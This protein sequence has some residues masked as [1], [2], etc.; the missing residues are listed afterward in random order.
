[1]DD[2]DLFGWDT[3]FAVNFTDTNAAIVAGHATPQ[4]FEYSDAETDV[5]IAGQW[6]DWQL[7]CGG[8]GQNAH[9]LC[10]ITQGTA[11]SGA[12]QTDLSGSWLKIEVRLAAVPDP[13]LAFEDPTGKGGV[14]HKLVVK[15]T[16]T[17]TD[18]AVSISASSFPHATGLLVRALPSIF[19]AYFIDNIALFNHVFSVVM[20]SETAY[21]DDY[22]WMKPTSMSYAV[23]DASDGSLDKS[24][25]S[26]LTMTGNKP[27]GIKPHAVDPRILDG[28]PEGAN[29]ALGLSGVNVLRHIFLPGAVAVIQGSKTEDYLIGDDGLWLENKADL[30]WGQFELDDGKIVQ[31]K[32]AAGKFRVG[33]EGDSV[34]L[35]ITGASFPWPSWHGPG[36]I[37]VSMNLVQ[38]FQF[39]LQPRGDGTYVFIPKTGSTDVE[40]V[41][42]DVTTSPGVDIFSVCMS[43]GT[44]VVLAIGGALFGKLLSCEGKIA[45]K[46]TKAAITIG[47]DVVE[48]TEALI[49]REGMQELEV[50]GAETASQA[51]KN[52]A[53]KSWTQ[54]FTSCIAAQ[55]WKILG[56]MFT[57]LASGLVGSTAELIKAAA[58]GDMEKIPPFDDFAETCLGATH[59]PNTEGFALKSAGLR[60]PLVITGLLTPSAPARARST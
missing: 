6:G 10:P 43:I 16:G 11:V 31:P 19:Q 50:E 42:A 26:M 22:A 57:A 40:D 54:K 58:E 37:T 60:G 17:E 39:E 47:K 34:R 56:G 29:A 3:T 14:A 24:V 27:I 28:L 32:I 36:E 7:T 4:S 2:I 44:A 33:L 5:S 20:L 23:A 38:Y 15:T 13:A 55:K 48:E 46:G 18:P 53:N 41:T 12:Q 1:M 21:V 25:F 51:V 35:E 59:W 8:D 30:T 9:I 52:A 49:G 45:A